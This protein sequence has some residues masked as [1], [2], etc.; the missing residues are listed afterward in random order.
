MKTIVRLFSFFIV[1]LVMCG[2]IMT[3]SARAEIVL[4]DGLKLGRRHQGSIGLGVPD[5]GGNSFIIL[6]QYNN[7]CGPTSVE[8]LLHYYGIDATLAD[9]WREGGIHNVDF[10]AFPGELKQALNRLGIPSRLLN[11]RSAN[12]T[13]FDS[14]ERKIRESRPPIVLLRQGDR[15]YHYVVVVGYDDSGGGSYLTA[16]PNGDFK[17]Y[18]RQELIPQWNLTKDTGNAAVGAFVG[19]AQFIGGAVPYTMISPDVAPTSHVRPLWS[20]MEAFQLAGKVQFFGKIRDWTRT[21][22]FPQPFDDYRLS[23]LRPIQW[24][25]LEGINVNLGHVSVENSWKRG[26]RQVKM[27]GR[28][29]DAWLTQGFGWVVVRAYSRTP[30]L[31]PSRF[32]VTGVTD[33]DR[34]PSGDTK[35]ITVTVYSDD[36]RRVPGVKIQIVDG[37]L[38]GTQIDNADKEISL[39]PLLISF[40]NSKVHKTDSN[41]RVKANMYTGSSGTANFTVIVDGL[42]RRTVDFTVVERRFTFERNRE[43]RGTF[44]AFCLGRF[45]DWVTWTKHV[46]VPSGTIKSS[47]TVKET[48]SSS[49]ANLK[50]WKWHDSNTVKV[51][52]RIRNGGCWGRYEWIKF[53]VEGTYTGTAPER[54]VNGAPP[55]TSEFDTLSEYWQDL[56]Q[57]PLQTELLTNYPNPFNPETW[58][59]YQLADAAE[60]EISIYAADG[61]LV[62]SLSLGHQS[63]GVYTSHSRAAHWDGKNEFGE[64]VAS[65]IYFYTLTAGEFTATRKM[66]ILK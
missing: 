9:V 42:G 24:N 44:Q 22:T 62:R 13:P 59:P 36:D 4:I 55:L 17:W 21:V 45:T 43:H 31:I 5:R 29:E 65:G 48:S 11:E 14:L 57:V 39:S 66:L 50:D 19:G 60:V 61:K 3:V 28:I 47:V 32:E 27:E 51:W 56:S 33:G 18:S 38:G 52:G 8:M 30:P 23:L 15:F 7:N 34:I 1:L 53:K 41:G 58:I 64:P 37:E 46:D 25:P 2:T 35:T 54:P 63:A 49:R 12:Y 6:K 26:D 40:S 20:Q 16:D 10:G